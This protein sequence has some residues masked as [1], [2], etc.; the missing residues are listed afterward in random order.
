MTTASLNPPST[1]AYKGAVLLASLGEELAARVLSFLPEEHVSVIAQ[2]FAR[3]KHVPTAQVHSVAKEF[4]IRME[5]VSGGINTGPEFARLILERAVGLEKTAQILGDT[6]K[7]VEAP[8]LAKTVENTIPESLAAAIF[9]EHPQMI[10][11]L[12]DQLDPDRAA[13]VLS[14]LPAEIQGQVTA[15][16]ARTQTPSP[17]AIQHLERRLADKLGG[18]TAPGET[19]IPGPQRVADILGRMQRSSET[20]VLNSL[21]EQSPQIAAEVNQ[22]RFGIEQFLELEDRII[23]RVLREVEPDKM[24][25]ILKGLDS[26]QHEIIL[27][28]M[29]ERGAERLKEDLEALGPARLRDVESAQRE[30]VSAARRLEEEGEISLRTTSAEGSN[31]EEVFV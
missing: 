4:E 10:A 12:L 3:I 20:A 27:R 11:L 13:A 2:E 14:A 1:G 26:E 18:S 24:V 28:N 31:D 19:G 15:R 8:S 9:G 16:L 5:E 29:S 21:Q 30:L 7:P 22:Y 17:L 23:Q 25:L 6:A